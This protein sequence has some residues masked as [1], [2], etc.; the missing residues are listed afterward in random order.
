MTFAIAQTIAA[1]VAGSEALMGDSAAMTV[2]ALTYLFNWYAERQKQ[3]YKE[4]K[5]KGNTTTTGKAVLEYRKYAYQLELIPPLLS[6]STLLVVTGFVLKK[7][8]QVLILDAKRD[9]SEQA[10]P[11]VELMMLFSCLNL[12]LDFLNVI[13]FAKAKHA[14]GFET[15]PDEDQDDD[16][17][18]VTTMRSLLDD[19]D[20]GSR[21]SD[22]LSI[23]SQDDDEDEEDD[24][25]EVAS[26][27]VKLEPLEIEDSSNCVTSDHHGDEEANLNM[28]S[29]YTVCTG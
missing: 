26:G 22:D 14:L 24:D 13:C 16:R 21:D 18:Q 4:E 8:I 7:A 9:V 3:A 5:L 6:V 27:K 20:L 15:N 2:D 11:N 10:D 28:C 12:L 1:F 29:A 23:G 25:D 19:D 17:R